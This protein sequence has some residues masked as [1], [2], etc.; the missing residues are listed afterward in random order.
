MRITKKILSNIEVI[1][2]EEKLKSKNQESNNQLNSDNNKLKNTIYQ[3]TS[4]N[5]A[6]NNSLILNKIDNNIPI[7]VSLNKNKNDNY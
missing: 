6:D 4:N 2:N 7:K 3:P 5:L 1:N